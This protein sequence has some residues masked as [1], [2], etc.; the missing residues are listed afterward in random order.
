MVPTNMIYRIF[1]V[2]YMI[3]EGL[4]EGVAFS[5]DVDGKQYLVTARHVVD[6]TTVM[7]IYIFHDGRWARIDA[8]PLP[9]IPL[10]V[11]IAVLAPAMLL[12]D[13]GFALE[14]TAGGVALGQDVYIF[15]FPD[16]IAVRGQQSPPDSKFPLPFARKVSFSYLDN[17]SNGVQRIYLSGRSNPGFSGSP[18][19]FTDVVTGAFKVGG[20]VHGQIRVGGSVMKEGK[21]TEFDYYE[22]QGFIVTYGIKHAVEA[23]RRTPIGVP[24]N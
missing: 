16:I 21:A 10:D 6:A 17:G 8:T 12:T 20:V 9:G 4:S 15:G 5:L 19:F 22:D 11:D 3:P 2:G 24:H 23:I 18:V 14:A 7:P 1:R 13:P